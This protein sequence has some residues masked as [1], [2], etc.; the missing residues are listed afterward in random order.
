MRLKL[1]STLAERGSLGAGALGDEDEKLHNGQ[2]R[3]VS[4]ECVRPDVPPCTSASELTRAV[5]SHW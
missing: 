1:I 2:R 4:V 3:K 5:A